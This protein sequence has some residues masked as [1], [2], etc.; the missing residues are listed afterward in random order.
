MRCVCLPCTMGAVILRVPTVPLANR[1]FTLLDCFHTPLLLMHWGERAKTGSSQRAPLP[2]L[3]HGEGGG[4][5]RATTGVL[6]PHTGH[7][8]LACSIVCN[9][10]RQPCNPETRQA[11]VR[12]HPYPLYYT[13]RG[14]G[15]GG[16]LQGF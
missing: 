15:G 14:G 5:G 6:K 8:L 1:T 3:L 13:G 11:A 4:G 2:P 10:S 16:L 9:R 12:G 7:I